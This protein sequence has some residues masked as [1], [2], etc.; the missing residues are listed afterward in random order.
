MIVAIRDPSLLE[1]PCQIGETGASCY[2]F[3]LVTFYEK[4]IRC[5]ISVNAYIQ[6][7]IHVNKM[8]DNIDIP[9]CS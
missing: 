9:Y 5:I 2:N 4:Y 6:F 3:L 8:Y 7:I 1:P